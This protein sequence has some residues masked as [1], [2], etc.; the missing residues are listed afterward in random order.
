M[1]RRAPGLWRADFCLLFLVLTFGVSAWLSTWSP[2]LTWITIPYMAI[3]FGR[4]SLP[5]VR[6][7]GRFGDLSYGLY[8]YGFP[9]QQAVLWAMPGITYPVLTAVSATAVMAL[10]SWH[11]VERPALAPRAGRSASLAA[12]SG[13]AR[14][15]LEEGSAF[16]QT[17]RPPSARS[18]GPLDPLL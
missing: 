12:F 1:E 9:V 13:V 18:Q 10:L 11:L 14:V 4:G 5:L 8:L 2:P 17:S 15:A 3:A 7:A 6:R 16:L